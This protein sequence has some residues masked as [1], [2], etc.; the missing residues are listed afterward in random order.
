M[1]VFAIEQHES[2]ICIYIY[3]CVCVCVCV[4]VYSLTPEPLSHPHSSQPTLL[5]RRSI[6]SWA[7]WATRQLLN[8][9]PSCIW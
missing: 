8:N 1:L 4:C 9:Y 2:A 7:P 5:G 6:L 3:V